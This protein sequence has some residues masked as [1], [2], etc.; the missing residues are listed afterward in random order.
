MQVIGVIVGLVWGVIA[1][2]GAL[3]LVGF[4][5]LNAGLV[6]QQPLSP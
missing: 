6:R 1:L 4:A 5:A 2:Q 3:G